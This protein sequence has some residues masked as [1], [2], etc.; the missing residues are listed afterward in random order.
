MLIFDINKHKSAKCNSINQNSF[1]TTD[2]VTLQRHTTWLYGC[3]YV[4]YIAATTARALLLFR[5]ERMNRY[6]SY[7]LQNVLY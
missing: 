5:G 1:Y 6:S 2:I 7:L 4:A 3:M